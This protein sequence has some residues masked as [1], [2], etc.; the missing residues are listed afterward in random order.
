MQLVEFPPCL[1]NVLLSSLY[2]KKSAVIFVQIPCTSSIG[3]LLCS[4]TR[5]SCMFHLVLILCISSK[6]GLVFLVLCS[7]LMT[8][9][10]CSVV[11]LI[12]LFVLIISMVR[13]YFNKTFCVGIKKLRT[14]LFLPFC[15]E[16]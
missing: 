6:D 15:S 4:D 7:S 1:S 8:M 11:M 9:S 16:V 14:V 13:Y 10:V 3:Y 5:F 2:N 12:V